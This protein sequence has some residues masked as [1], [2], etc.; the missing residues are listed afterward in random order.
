MLL[1][2]LLLNACFLIDTKIKKISLMKSL[3]KTLPFLLD[4]AM[5]NVSNSMLI[6]GSTF[7]QNTILKH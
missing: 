3:T 1:L 5:M 2:A 6:K 4:L 7:A